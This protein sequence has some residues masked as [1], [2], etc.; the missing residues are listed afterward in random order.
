VDEDSKRRMGG[1]LSRLLKTL[2]LI[3]SREGLLRT[4]RRGV[5]CAPERG[6]NEA[7]RSMNSTG[8]L[9]IAVLRLA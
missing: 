3:V 6:T 8:L 5:L 2:N 4:R 1:D 7:G 9:S